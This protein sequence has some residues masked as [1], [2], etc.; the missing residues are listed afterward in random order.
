MPRRRLF[1][2][3]TG[4]LIVAGALVGALLATGR[5]G[6]SQPQPRG[7]PYRGSEPPAGIRIPNATLPSYRGGIVSLRAQHGK[8]LVLTFLDSK[9][10]D[11][12]PIIAALIGRTWPLLTA[13]EK[14][15][16]RVYAIT[17]NPLADTPAR[18]RSFLAARHALTALDW[19]VAPVKE[20]RPVWHDFGVLP[21]TDTGNDN[22]HSADVRVF[23]RDG[24]W[25]SNLHAGVDLTP[26]NLVHDIRLALRA[27][28][29]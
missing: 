6:A 29:T 26:A 27:G 1:I 2:F 3:I 19:L 8:V 10:T 5:S 4:W 23:N 9:C 17:V 15:R 14:S 25:V 18:V 28:T 20:M 16:I 22:I 13:G 24:I 21:A 11:T 12:C 7:R